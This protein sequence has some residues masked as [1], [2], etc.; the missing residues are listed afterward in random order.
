MIKREP[1]WICPICWHT[2]VVDPKKS[3]PLCS[4]MSTK[5]QAVMKDIS[6]NHPSVWFAEFST[7]FVDG[8][9]KTR[10]LEIASV[11]PQQTWENV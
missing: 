11:V 8:A 1:N 10:L 5:E 2:H 3:C 6:N 4:K 7:L 9:L